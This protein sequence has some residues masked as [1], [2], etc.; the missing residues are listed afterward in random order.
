MLSQ[1]LGG[2][3]STT[4]F[5]LSKHVGKKIRMFVIMFAFNMAIQRRSAN[6]MG[7]NPL[8]YPIIFQ[9]IPLYFHWG[10][11]YIPLFVA[12]PFP[13]GSFHDN[14]GFLQ[15]SGFLTR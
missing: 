11:L 13:Y 4:G 15:G 5:C 9:C 3:E 12:F 1:S 7:S 2:L 10:W 8:D 6:F 14:F